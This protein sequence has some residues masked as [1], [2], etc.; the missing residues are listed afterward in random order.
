MTQC[1]QKT[2]SFARHFSREVAVDFKAGRI[3][4]NGGSLLLREV[5]KRVNL[6]ER[7]TAY[8]QDGRNPKLIH[9]QLQEMI[10]QRVYVWRWVMKTSMTMSNCDTIR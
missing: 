1:I 2:F 9:H 8:F 4:S 5:D 10:A 7:F 3:S 6:I